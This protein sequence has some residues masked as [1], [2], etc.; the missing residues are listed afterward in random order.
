M[1]TLTHALT[2]TK[3]A[4]DSL[5]EGTANGV[6]TFAW[7]LPGFAEPLDVS[8]ELLEP[9]AGVQQKTIDILNEL[10]AVLPSQREH[11]RELLYKDAL[12]ARDTTAYGDP[13]AA[14]VPIKK[15]IWE[16]ITGAPTAY[17]FVPISIADPRHPCNFQ[18]GAN[19]V[20]SKVKYVGFEIQETDSCT[21]RLCYLHTFPAWEEE[22]GCRIVIRNG[23]PVTLCDD[24]D[25]LND[26]DSI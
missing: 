15:T 12:R 21:H 14:Q 22:H 2:F 1:L 13:Q 9:F 25:M 20:D 7:Q 23:I 18:G 16:R 6:G 24:P 11:I 17:E 10:S 19:G 8:I 4:V 3:E 5:I 26:Y